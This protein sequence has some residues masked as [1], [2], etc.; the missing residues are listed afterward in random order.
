MDAECIAN[1]KRKLS[2]ESENGNELNADS[3]S[4]TV[5]NETCPMDDENGQSGNDIADDLR[6]FDVLDEVQ[7][8]DSGSENGQNGKMASTIYMNYH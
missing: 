5:S 4:L 7:G 8:D 3:N 6:Q 1:R 2:M